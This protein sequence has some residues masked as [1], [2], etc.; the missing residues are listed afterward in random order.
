MVLQKREVYTLQL[1]KSTKNWMDGVLF[2]E[3][4]REMVIN[5][6]PVHPQ[7][8]NL[9]SPPTGNNFKES[10]NGQGCDSLTE[11]TVP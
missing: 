8:E 9:K 5:N 2:E 3:W 6:C 1:Q 4:V 10:A 7:T 11:S